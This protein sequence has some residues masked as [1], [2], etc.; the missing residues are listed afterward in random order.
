M[1]HYRAEISLSCI[2][3]LPFAVLRRYFTA[4][5]KIWKA[6]LVA[7]I[8]SSYFSIMQNMPSYAAAHLGKYFKQVDIPSPASHTAISTKTST[9]NRHLKIIVGAGLSSVNNSVLT[10]VILLFDGPTMEISAPG[11]M[12][13]NIAYMCLRHQL[14]AEI[15]ASKC[16]S[17]SKSP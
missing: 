10:I 9:S 15:A 5:N 13:L 12:D 1:R 6:S 7:L 14:A 17:S 2:G 16:A 4:L 8:L 11:L 3:L